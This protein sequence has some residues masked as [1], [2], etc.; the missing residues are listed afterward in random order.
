MFTYWILS[1][2]FALIEQLAGEM[3]VMGWGT[4]ALHAGMAIAF[5]AF[6]FR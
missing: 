6:L 1:T 5:G 2:I 4:V 3:N